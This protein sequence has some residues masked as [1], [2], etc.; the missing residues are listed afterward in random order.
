MQ[1]PFPEDWLGFSTIS[2]M[3]TLKPFNGVRNQLAE[4]FIFASYPDVKV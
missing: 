4:D 3:Q 1:I 2:L